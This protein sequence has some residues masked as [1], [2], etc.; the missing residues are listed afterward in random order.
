M[1]KVTALASV[2][3]T[4][5][6]SSA[7]TPARRTAPSKV[8][9]RLTSISTLRGAG[10]ASARAATG[11]LAGLEVVE[12]VEGDGLGERVGDLA[13]LVGGDAGAADRA[14][15]G[16]AAADFDQHIARRGRGLSQ[17]GDR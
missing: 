8:S 9:P 17:G 4:S 10:G 14:L 12:D 6:A 5:R 16:L 15:E 11:A 2:L 13:G 3:A 7:A 1:L